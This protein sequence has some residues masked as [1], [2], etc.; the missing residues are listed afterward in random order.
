MDFQFQQRQLQS[1][2]Q[3]LSQKQIHALKVLSLGTA[4]L[5][6]LVEKNLQ[7]NPALILSQN[8]QYPYLDS[9]HI[10]RTS[11]AGEMESEKFQNILEAQ[12]D[13]RESLQSHLLGQLNYL[14][15]S[16]SEHDLCESLIYNLDSKGHH[17]VSPASLLKRGQSSGLLEK[18]I[19]IVQQLEPEGC[20]VKNHEESLLVQAKMK[21]HPDEIALFILDGHFDF[22]DPFKE[23]R[24]YSKIK[25]YIVQ[26]KKMFGNR[27]DYSPLLEIL[28]VESV[29][30]AM[31]FIHG[32][33]PFPAKEFSVDE[34]HAI[35]PD[36]IVEVL[37]D[38]YEVTLN[39]EI[40]VTGSRK[41]KLSYISDSIPDLQLNQELVELS[42]KSA[43]ISENI[44]KARD[45][46]EAIAY[47]QRTMKSAINIIARI[48][49]DFF[50]HGPG[51]LVPLKLQDIA[52]ELKIHETTVSRLSNSKYIQCEWGV[53]SLKYFF[54]NA[55]SK[56]S[57]DISRD[58]VLS[59]IKKIVYEN[60]K[61]SDQKISDLLNERKIHVSRRTVAKYRGLLN[62]DSSY[63]R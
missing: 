31:K 52:D 38:G 42:E 39:D 50:I 63:D 19:S 43:E 23:D 26:Q 9:V 45:F 49:S 37:P 8:K 34:N 1:Q 62:I 2:I 29:R 7:E 51:H 47:R 17:Y 55:V 40:I 27:K 10:G 14:N 36:V 25:D 53:F 21:P 61:I 5:N 56:K 48:Q 57:S 60:K 44:R 12:A 28:S 46:I 32:L 6:D 35:K 20:C 4:D 58:M 13:K 16:K 59:E 3:T 54:T 33:D 18:C 15:L 24:I 22:L 41:L 11:S 30:H